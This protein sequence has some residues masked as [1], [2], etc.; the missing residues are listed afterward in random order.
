[1]G[2]RVK[3]WQP[4]VAAEIDRLKVPLPAELVLAIMQRESNGRVGIK[5][6]K[7]GASGLM[8]VMPIALKDYNQNNRVQYTMGHLRQT[9][10]SAAQ[11]Q[12]R[13]GLWILARFIKGAYRYLKKRLGTVPLDDLIKVADTFYAAGPAASKRRLDKLNRPNWINIRRRFPT[14]DRIL[15]AELVWR[16]T[17]DWDAN[18]Q[19]NELDRWLEGQL[20]IDDNKKINGALIGI[21]IILAAWMFMSKKGKK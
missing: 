9:T 8:Q 15:P 5:N 1:M 12:I 16:R 11:I 6:P 17:T 2:P 21:L 3:K 7:S 20:V 14:W 13:V 10:Q 18:W 4:V 19:L